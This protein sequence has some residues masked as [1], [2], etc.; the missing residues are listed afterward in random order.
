MVETQLCKLRGTSDTFHLFTALALST[1]IRFCFLLLVGM[2]TILR[3]HDLPRHIS[4]FF[5]RVE[6]QTSERFPNV[7]GVG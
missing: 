6:L 7:Q 2:S 4:G 1:P 3:G 5:Q